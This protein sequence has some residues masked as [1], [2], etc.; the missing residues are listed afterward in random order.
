MYPWVKEQTKPIPVFEAVQK[1]NVQ[2][3]HATLIPPG[4]GYYLTFPVTWKSNFDMCTWPQLSH[5]EG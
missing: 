3:A 1:G 5:A 2:S 4:P